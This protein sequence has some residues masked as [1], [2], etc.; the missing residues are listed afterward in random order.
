MKKIQLGGHIK[1]S[2]IR[3]Y[4][5][6][7]DEDYLFLIKWRWFLDSTGYPARDE[8]KKRYR[9]HVVIMKPLAGMEVDHINS[10]KLDNR[11]ENLRVA[12]HQQNMY[13][14][15]GSLNKT[16][17][18]KGVR[19]RKGRGCWMAAIEYN[20]KRYYLGSFLVE[21]HA[22][23]SYDIWAKELFGEFAKLNFPDAI[24]G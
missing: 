20:R 21:R 16:S 23:M 2:K 24:H 7:D 17:I 9:M 8:L 3:G 6:V 11:K 22:A 4:A 18:Y 14:R 1:N 15:V 12:T 13:N 19:Y 5:I 10:N